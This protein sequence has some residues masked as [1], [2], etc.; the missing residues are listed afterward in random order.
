MVV[1]IDRRPLEPWLSAG[2]YAADADF[3][4]RFQGWLASVW[5]A[6]DA[7]LAQLLGASEGR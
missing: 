7:R 5:A 4:R 2:D 3:R 6:K 1:E